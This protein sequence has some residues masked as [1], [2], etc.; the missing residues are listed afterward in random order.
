VIDAAL[1]QLARRPPLARSAEVGGGDAVR[2]A[3]RPLDQLDIQRHGAISTTASTG[4][5]RSL[6]G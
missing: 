1:A 3:G 6:M 2:V 4:F 5:P